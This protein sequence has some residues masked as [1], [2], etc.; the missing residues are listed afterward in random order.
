MTKKTYGALAVAFV[1]GLSSCSD[2]N[3]WMDLESG[4]G[5]IKLSLKADGQVSSAI[6]RT[7]AEGDA[8][9]AVPEVEAFNIHL[10]K[11]T[12]E[13]QIHCSHD[14]FLKQNSFPTGIYTLQA[15][16]GDINKE[17]FESPYFEGNADVTV[18]ENRQTEVSVSA[19]VANS[20]VSVDYTDGF[21][22]YMKSWS[23]TVHS[24]GHSYVE[25]PADEKRPAFLHPGDVEVA[26]TFTN[27]QGQQLTLSPAEFPAEP[28]HHYNVMLDVNQ[29]NNGVAV[30]SVVFDDA[31]TAE[32]VNIDLTDELFTSPAPKVNLK[33]IAGAEGS[34][35]VPALEFIAGTA[36]V[37]QY[38]YDVLSY[39]GLRDVRL[40]LNVISGDMGLAR[41]LNLITASESA[42]GQLAALGIEC[43]GIFKNPD[44]M[45]IIDF[46]KLPSMLPA[47]E[48]ELTV[49]ATDLLTRQSAPSTVRIMSVSPTLTVT[50]ESAIY[51]LNTGTL[52]LKYNG[53]N[54]N[55][56]VTF[57]A[58]DKYGQYVD[59]PIIPNMTRQARRRIIEEKEYYITIKL[60][61]FGDRT[62]VP[63]KVFLFGKEVD[64]VSL[65]VEFPKYD[66]AVDAFA[67]KV[68]LKIT[69]ENESLVPV[70]TES[71]KIYN[72]GTQLKN[73]VSRNADTGIIT[74]S[75]LEPQQN[76]DLVVSLLNA[77][78]EAKNISFV[79]EEARSL[80][81]GDFSDVSQTI[82]L[83]NVQSG[84]P[85]TGIAFNLNSTPK[86]YVKVN[87]RR[88]TPD[89]WATLNSLTCYTGSEN[90]NTWFM[91]PSTWTEGGETIIR[92]VG[93]NHKG[94]TPASSAGTADYWCK[95]APTQ[96]QLDKAAGELFLGS[97]AFTGREER[98][99][100]VAWNTRPSGL[101]F[102]YKYAPVN[103]EEG[104][105][106]IIVLSASNEVLASSTVALG[107]SAQSK[108]T[109]ID[110]SGYP[111]GSRADRIMVGF[112]STRTGLTPAVNI[113]TG[114]ALNDNVAKWNNFT[115][116]VSLPDNEYKAVATGSTL[117][118][119]NVK[120]IY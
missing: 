10:R 77:N 112:K 84:G 3:P 33:G 87:I 104:E 67:K 42:Q 119:S 108:S 47:G 120:L 66:V 101:T 107:S 9:F 29:G 1:L 96:A 79:T 18:L 48:Y 80:V 24:A 57:K 4:Q 81:N 45:A 110:L 8:L 82:D 69:P 61:D 46:S 93:Y 13:T 118:I 95:N 105:A 111:F 59:A 26:V 40:T 86:Y 19:R 102:D 54:P 37:G 64:N 89:N 113:P 60:P 106:Y 17:G 36:P 56:D 88:S 117:T 97:Y 92:S 68:L 12:G 63:V 55:D 91:V 99:D 52:S 90:K 44:K 85:F 22:K 38:R 114:D 2:D 109:T 32:T 65:P 71:L 11:S 73:N 70:I 7:K 41:E 14:E 94:V 28:G 30:L 20:L 53:S 43:K 25:V 39:G 83:Q 6:P 5:A 51:G 27:P 115:Q 74:V 62:E 75:G 72:G 58:M 98:E 15:Y 35:E 23:S 31:L 16:Y 50:P 103:D 49:V 116:N 78:T 21:K 34:D 76:Y 100:G